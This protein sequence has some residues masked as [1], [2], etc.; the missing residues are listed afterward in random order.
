MTQLK[1]E[2]CNAEVKVGDKTCKGCGI[3][4]PPNFGK[5]PQ[6]KFIYWFIALVIFCF[7]MMFWL[8]PDWTKYISK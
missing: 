5:N 6:R 1:C 2:H 8:P 3:P 4:L 7:F